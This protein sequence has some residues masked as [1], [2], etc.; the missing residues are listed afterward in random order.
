MDKTLM[1]LLNDG[2]IR[3]EDKE[4]IGREPD[5][6]EVIFKTATE[7]REFVERYQEKESE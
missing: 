4:I 1:K 2:T 5:G 7:L 6:T 3:F